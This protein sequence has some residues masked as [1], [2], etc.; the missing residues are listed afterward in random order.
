MSDEDP[1]GGVEEGEGEEDVLQAVD[2]GEVA[3]L[4]PHTDPF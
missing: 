2:D 4:S 1:G 3:V